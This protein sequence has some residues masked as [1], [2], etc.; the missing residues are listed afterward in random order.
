MMNE[1]L[2]YIVIYQ[3]P[4]GRENIKKL[5]HVRS[6]YLRIKCKQVRFSRSRLSM[7]RGK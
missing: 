2:N 4:E 1:D 3:S 5:L 6:D 7:I